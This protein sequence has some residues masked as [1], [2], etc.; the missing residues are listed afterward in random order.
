MHGKWFEF[1]R[2]GCNLTIAMANRLGSVRSNTERRHFARRAYGLEPG[3][4]AEGG[5]NDNEGHAEGGDQPDAQRHG[6]QGIGG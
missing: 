6:R 4:G 5:T 3:T 1:N 2:M